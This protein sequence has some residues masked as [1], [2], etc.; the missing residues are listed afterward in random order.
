MTQ[1]PVSWLPLSLAEHYSYPERLRETSTNRN[2]EAHFL[3][4]ITSSFCS[5]VRG[6]VM[7][8]AS[9]G[10]S[11]SEGSYNTLPGNENFYF[12]F[13]YPREGRVGSKQ[14]GGFL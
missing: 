14:N 3:D 11:I 12:L 8:G 6:M 9:S 1:I 13:L 10:V 7:W 4:I 5:Y 2:E